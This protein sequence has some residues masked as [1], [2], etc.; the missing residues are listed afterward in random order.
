MTDVRA[1]LGDFEVMPVGSQERMRE[2]EQRCRDLAD[3]LWAVRKGRGSWWP[4]FADQ[5]D[6]IS[7][8]QKRFHIQVDKFGAPMMTDALRAEISRARFAVGILEGSSIDLDGMFDADG[9]ALGP[10]HD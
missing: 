10:R 6:S 4:G 3:L 2:L 1:S 7:I 8:N 9:A 5:P